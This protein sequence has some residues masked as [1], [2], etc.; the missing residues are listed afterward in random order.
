MHLLIAIKGG[1]KSSLIRSILFDL[2]EFSRVYL[3]LSEENI[4][5]YLAPLASA[6]RKIYSEDEVESRMKNLLVTSE[7]DGEIKPE[8][9]LEKIELNI[10]KHRASV[11]IF[12]NITTS[13]ISATNPMQQHNF[14]T[15][16]SVMT[17]K[18]N[19]ATMVVA[20]TKKG[21]NKNKV[22]DGDDIRGVSTLTNTSGY[23]YTLN[24]F[25]QLTPPV[26]VLKNDKARYHSNA[27]LK[28]YGLIWDKNNNIFKGDFQLSLDEYIS[29]EK[30]INERMKQKDKK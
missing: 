6:L 25:F 27:H 22:A 24:T 9:F 20:H 3:H 2:L 19:I 29:I 1:G 23:I 14:A 26:T 16:I 17:E 11:F 28:N 8:N 18:M 13:G 10:T 21:H 30:S 4:L 15:G 12:D 5:K 7:K